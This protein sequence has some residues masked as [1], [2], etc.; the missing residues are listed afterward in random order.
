MLLRLLT[1]DF[2]NGAATELADFLT[3]VMWAIKGVAISRAKAKPSI[4]F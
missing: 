3:M 1:I 4:I 2:C